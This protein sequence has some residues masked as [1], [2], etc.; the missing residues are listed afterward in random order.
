MLPLVPRGFSLLLLIYVWNSRLSFIPK[1]SFL[2]TVAVYFMWNKR[3]SLV[4]QKCVLLMV[5]NF[6]I[7]VYFIYETKHCRWLHEVFVSLLGGIYMWDKRLA[8]F[9]CG[10]K[11]WQRLPR[12]LVSNVHYFQ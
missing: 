10:T 12:K 7:I 11:D 6:I 4:P 8:I 3:L 5:I 1:M 2:F 9:I